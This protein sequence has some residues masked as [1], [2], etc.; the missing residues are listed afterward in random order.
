MLPPVTRQYCHIGT[1][2][3]AYLD[4]APKHNELRAI[5][6]LHAFPI[7]ANLWEPQMRSIPGGW[8]LITPDLR[9]FGGSTE[10]DSL[11]ALLIADYAA[12]V[13]DLLAELGIRKAVIGGCSMGGYAA[14][15]LYQA[16][17]RLF[18]GMVLANTRAGAD[19][20]EAR[21]NR[22]N[23]LALVDREGPLGVAREMMPKLLG[24]TTRDTN[25]TAEATV[26]R[27]IK[28]QSPVAI[29]SAIH[30]MMHRPDSMPLLSRVSVPTL[31]ITGAEDELIPVDESRRM[32]SAIPGAT[33][34]IIPGAGHLANLEQPD[35]F[36]AA[37]A[38]FLDTL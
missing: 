7:G 25:A 13:M 22:R 24:S 36:N 10:L 28:Q 29:R 38:D 21:A 1:R 17:P 31:V 37:L 5:V 9:G 4:S 27:F 14:L 32:A 2:T 6:L 8:R 11:S 12:D 26:R 15:A 20:P 34:V 33:L 16:E 30:R 23:M 3:I 35:A 19:S 18:D